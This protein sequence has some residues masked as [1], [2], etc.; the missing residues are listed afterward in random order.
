MLSLPD[1]L[2]S[3]SQSKSCLPWCARVVTPGKPSAPHNATWP[4]REAGLQQSP[5]PEQHDHHR[6]SQGASL[7]SSN[8]Q[9]PV[10]KG[11]NRNHRK[12]YL[13]FQKT[14][15]VMSGWMFHRSSDTFPTSASSGWKV[16]MSIFCSTHFF[17]LSGIG[18]CG[19]KLG[20]CRLEFLKRNKF[21]S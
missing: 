9:L 20:S 21:T 4:R 6:I 13:V 1:F 2:S 18:Y 19:R 16:R 7:L 8:S 17:S 14:A 10:V 12:V 3:S 15:P 11:A 5:L